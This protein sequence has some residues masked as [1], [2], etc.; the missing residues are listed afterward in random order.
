M[1]ELYV[2]KVK[3]SG[4]EGSPKIPPKNGNVELHTSQ[5]DEP[6]SSVVMFPPSPSSVFAPCALN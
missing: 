1:R 4:N 2:A 5:L 6:S 3:R